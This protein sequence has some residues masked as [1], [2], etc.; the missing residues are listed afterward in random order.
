MSATLGRGRAQPLERS[1]IRLGSGADGLQRLAAFFSD[2]GFAPH[3]HVTYGIGVTTS[4]V[5]AFRYRGERH[6]C[7]PGQMHI[8][9]PDETHDGTTATEAGFG[10]RIIYLDPD[11]VGA[12][13]DGRPLPF[14]PQP[15]HD[16][17]PAHLLALLGDIDEPIS[18][19]AR[20]DAATYLADTLVRLGDRPISRGAAVDTKAV[21]LVRD[22]LEAHAAEPVS[23]HDLELLTGLDR[24]TLARHFRRVCGTSPDRYRMARRLDVARGAIR[25]GT[26]LARAAAEAGFA[27][28]SHLTRQ[29]KLAYG[30]PPGRWTAL[31]R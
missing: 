16:R 13:L 20:T 19:L 4:G 12:A 11:L 29:F 10:Y 3:R 28:Q 26:P 7:R 24:F 22:Y 30:L 31:S 17:P 25:S 9:H 8:L 23:S 1:C 21:A 2:D 5:Q 18:D 14:V 6:L 15:V 27:D